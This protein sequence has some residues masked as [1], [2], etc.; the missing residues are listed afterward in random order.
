ME[1]LRGNPLRGNPSGTYG[2][3]RVTSLAKIVLSPRAEIPLTRPNFIRRVTLQIERTD[4]IVSTPE[5]W[6]IVTR[7]TRNRSFTR[8]VK[9]IIID[10]VHLLHDDRGPV[11]ESIVARTIQQVE[12]THEMTRLVGLALILILIL[13]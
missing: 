2:K 7:K 3:G 10:E 13:C 8:L 11:L 9:L 1:P 5:K 6:D 4:I 12:A